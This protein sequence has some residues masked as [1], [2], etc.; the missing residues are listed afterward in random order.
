MTK[1]GALQRDVMDLIT[2]TAGDAELILAPSLGGAVVSWTRAGHAVFR[3]PLPNAL[4]DGFVRGLA[5]FPL[6]PW[7]NRIAHGRFSFGGQ[8]YQLPATFGGHA[9]HGTGW[10]SVWQAPEQDATSAT[11]T[12]LHAPDELW[13]FAFEASQRFM[14]DADRLT[15]ALSVTNRHSGPA[16]FALGAH[17]YFPKRPGATLQFSAGGVW[18]N[19]GEV[20][21]AEHIA[22]PAAWDHART[23]PI[24]V[25]DLDNCFTAWTGV[26][27]LTYPGPGFAV[28]ITGDPVFANLVVFISP[29]NDFFAVEPVSNVN[30]G[31][32]KLDEPVTHGV[33]VLEPGETL[34]GTMAFAI[35]EIHT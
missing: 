28:I 13:P 16:P 25:A 4:A 7:S 14:L 31:M 11:L 2:L 18:R 17:P 27:R 21:A 26:A 19:V 32:N 33:R 29:T 20:L 12:N 9:I 35:Q 22:V 1:G 24:G 23:L 8:S 15:L 30:D 5:S 34:A 10:Q 3:A 6:I